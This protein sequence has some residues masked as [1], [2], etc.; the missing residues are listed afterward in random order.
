MIFLPFSFMIFIR[1]AREVF[2]PEATGDA[3]DGEAGGDDD[4]VPAAPVRLALPHL[5]LGTAGEDPHV[6]AVQ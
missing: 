1:E 4:E 5:V 3:D 6:D 2:V